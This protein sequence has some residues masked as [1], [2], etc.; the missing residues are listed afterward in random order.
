MKE[1]KS[2]L[3][4]RLALFADPAIPAFGGAEEEIDPPSWRISSPDPARKLPGKGLAQH[5]ML[6]VGEGCNRMFLVHEGRILWT[7][8]AGKGWEYD[9]MWMLS[10]GNILFSRM[11]WAG[12]VSPRKEMLWRMDAPAGT[13]I[14]TVQPVGQDRVLL[15]L[16][17]LPPQAMI[18]NARTGA[19]EMRHALEYDPSL[20]VHSQCRRFRMTA[21]GTFLAPYLGMSRVVE[22]DRDF[23]PIW[24]FEVE[25]PWAAVRL[26]NGNTLITDEASRAHLEIT[27]D[28]RAAWSI[29]LAELP[30]AYRLHD[31]QSC[32]RLSNGNTILCSRG[33]DGLAPQMVEVTRD[34]EVVWVFDDWSQIGPVTAVQVLSE[35]GVPEIPGALER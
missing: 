2:P 20:S 1:I 29:R 24:S 21:Q 34:K 14:H 11:T 10:S 4:E 35:P 26:R 30:E 18:I 17:D 27:P 9:D 33:N 13:E 12:I 32:T 23:Q 8:C 7:F 5:S 6:I 16:N 25:R 19:V 3:L 22:Y 31:S 15:V 28:K